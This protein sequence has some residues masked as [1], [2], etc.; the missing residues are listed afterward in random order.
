[1]RVWS[2]SDLYDRFPRLQDEAHEIK[3]EPAGYNCVAWVEGITDRYIDPTLDWPREVPKPEGE[4]DE[5]LWCY[6]ALFRHY[7][8][9]VCAN[10][11]LEDG[12]IKIAV[13]ADGGWFAHVAKQ[14]PSGKWTSKA[15]FLH[16]LNHDRLEALAGCSFMKNAVPVLFMRRRR[17][18]QQKD[19]E[20][21]GLLLPPFAT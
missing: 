16:D 5:D 11:S 13:Y 14:M 19:Q 6:E 9:E 1:V 8:Y 20:W 4:G 18:T 12:F 15:G 21:S 10:G 17:T 2:L 3:S 7:G